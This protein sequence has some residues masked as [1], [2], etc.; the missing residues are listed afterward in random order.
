MDDVIGIK[1]VKLKGKLQK[2]VSDNFELEGK[3]GDLL[4][5]EEALPNIE[6]IFEK[7]IY[8]N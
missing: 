2:I 3:S 8:K 7:G 6:K 4:D 1:S 5:A